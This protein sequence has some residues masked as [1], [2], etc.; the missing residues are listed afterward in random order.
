[1]VWL[2]LSPIPVGGGVTSSFKLFL[3]VEEGGGVG[4]LWITLVV[5]ILPHGHHDVV[6][7]KAG[8]LLLCQLDEVFN[9]QLATLLLTV[10]PTLGRTFLPVWLKNTTAL[11]GK[12][13][14]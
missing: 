9:L 3:P 8:S 10:L 12:V 13:V 5:E 4:A 14:P 2:N 6:G 7:K 11:R 1:M